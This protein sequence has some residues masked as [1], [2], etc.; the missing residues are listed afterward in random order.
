MAKETTFP[1]IRTNQEFK[2]QVYEACDSI[3]LKYSN[4]VTR[5]LERWVSGEVKLEMELKDNSKKRSVRK[6]GH[7]GASK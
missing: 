5:L 3:G 4:V 6:K 2:D 1:G 7:E